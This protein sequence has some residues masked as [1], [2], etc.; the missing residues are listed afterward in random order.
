MSMKPFTEFVPLQTHHCVTGSM[1]HIY[2][3]NGCDVSEELLLGLGEGV[4]FM[5]WQAKGQPPF[6]GGRAFP[7][8]GMETIAG[9]RTGVRIEDHHTGSSS[10]ARQALL[11][12]LSARQPVMVQVDMGFLP[13]FNFGGQEYHFGGHVVVVCGCNPQTGQVLIAER[14]G[15]HPI[16]MA[17]LEQ[18]RSSTFK[19]FPPGNT[20]WSFEFGGFHPPAAQAVRLAIANHA[21]AMLQPPIR[22]MGVK[23]I[24]TAAERIQ[25]W[26]K[27]MSSE[28]IRLA[29]F[30]T[31]IFISSVGGSGGGIFRYMFGRFLQEAAIITGEP[32]LSESAA[33][34]KRIGDAWESFAGWAKAV[35]GIPDPAARL[36]ESAAPLLEI[37]DQEQAAWEKLQLLTAN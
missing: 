5:Y 22:N 24:R 21:N 4:G 37:A 2:A 36:Q 3:F 15:L 18:A 8:P 34:F 33:E 9:Q 16:P 11:G 7:K 17:D 23:G 14:D 1:R 35:S 20:W 30:N 28:N 27:Q 25:L 12:M 26:P 10:K 19:P 29:L 6:L 13:Y 31:F 32:R